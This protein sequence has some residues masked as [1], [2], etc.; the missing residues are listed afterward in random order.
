MFEPISIKR[1]TDS[2]AELLDL[3]AAKEQL[4]IIEFTGDDPYLTGLIKAAR[5]IVETAT[6]R[7]LAPGQTWTAGY[8][9][10]P[11]DRCLRI[12]TPPLVSVTSLQYYDSSNNLQTLAADDYVVDSS[13][14]GEC[15]ILALKRTATRPLISSD[16][17]APVRIEFSAGYADLAGIPHNLL[18]AQ[19]Y[20][21]AHLYENRVPLGINVNVNELPMTYQYLINPFKVRSGY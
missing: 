17:F 9:G 3:A 6:A 5:H 12:P 8:E 19:K 20:M 16:Y 7:A 1:T 13:S 18:A 10:I 11:L 4:N 15:A 2:S 21:I 14:A